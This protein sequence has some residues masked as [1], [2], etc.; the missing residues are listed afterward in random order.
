MSVVLSCLI[1]WMMTSDVSSGFSRV[2]RRMPI[3]FLVL[4][5]IHR[6]VCQQLPQPT[7]VC[8]GCSDHCQVA[9]QTDERQ[10][11]DAAIQVDGVDHVHA[12]ASGPSKAPVIQSCIHCPEGKSQNK[13]EVGS[14]EMEAIPVCQAALWPVGM[15]RIWSMHS[16]LSPS[17][18]APAFL[19]SLTCA[20]SPTPRP[21]DRFR[22]CLRWRLWRRPRARRP[23]EARRSSRA[24]HC[25]TLPGSLRRP[26][27]QNQSLCRWSQGRHAEGT[28]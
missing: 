22:L 4:T 19:S 28:W 17:A 18:P 16:F 21:P 14:R 10:D 9:V 20:G 23:G 27:S 11:E 25:K 15:E 5:Y 26:R 2:K 12:D 8:A 1:F 7:G 13:E 24:P 3:C 6:L